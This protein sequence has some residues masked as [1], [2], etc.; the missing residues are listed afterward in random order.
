MAGATALCKAD[1][2]IES[3]RLAPL[4]ALNTIEVLFE[5]IRKEWILGLARR[6][7]SVY[8]EIG[9]L[10]FGHIN[11]HN[12]TYLTSLKLERP[13]E[14]SIEVSEEFQNDTI[15]C[16]LMLLQHRFEK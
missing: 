4:R 6:G 10:K 8:P 12:T 1:W 3:F 5:R 7:Y 14:S 16:F 11:I 15:E 2:K 9:N 13:S